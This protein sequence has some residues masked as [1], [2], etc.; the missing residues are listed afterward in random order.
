[1]FLSTAAA[2][3]DVNEPARAARQITEAF[4][5]ESF[6]PRMAHELND[7]FL[8]P[9]DKKKLYELAKKAGEQLQRVAEKQ[10]RLKQQIED[11]NGDDWDIRYGSTGLWRKLSADLY[12]TN[13]SKCE[14]DYYLALCSPPPQ[15]AKTAQDIL[16]RM[17]RLNQIRNTAYLQF[18]KAKTLAL[19]GRTELEYKPLA[20][21]EFNTLMVR[22]DMDHSISFRAAI[23]KIKLTGP[24]G[25]DQLDTLVKTLAQNY[26]DRYLELLL[27]AAF[28]QRRYTPQAFEKTVKL[29]PQIE[30]I[31]GSLILSALT[32]RQDQ[33]QQLSVFEAELAVQAIRRQDSAG[34]YK[35]LLDELCGTEKF[36]TP[37]ILYTA[38]GMTAESAPVKAA[39]LLVKA[40]TLQAS[41]K[42]SRLEI[43]AGRIAAQAAQMAYDLFVEDV[44]NCSLVLKAFDNYSTIAD[45]QFD[46]KLEYLYT[47]VLNNC[48]RGEQGKELL[49]KIAARA[50]GDWRNRAKRDLTVQ[51]IRQGR[52]ENQPALAEA[53]CCLL[54]VS[55]HNLCENIDE[56]MVLLSGIVDRIDSFREDDPKFMTDCKKL[57]QVC[58]D[59]LDSREKQTAGLFLA[60]VSIF[61]AAKNQKKL[62]GIEKLLDNLAKSSE[63]DDDT[64]LLR[65]RARLFAAQ[66]SFN[67][68]AN[69]WAQLCRMQENDTD[70]AN[71]P[72]RQWWRAKFYELDCWAK[73]PQTKKEDILHTIEV[74]NALPDIPPLWADKLKLLKQQCSGH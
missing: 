53:V 65:C 43:S 9:D 70:P 40:S 39:G 64:D 28:L 51:T 10:N 35:W 73:C 17:D 55:D 46:E 21:K 34:D 68:A 12:T 71:Q 33:V 16:A 44:N 42:N 45:N 1:L 8:S 72:S 22:S 50:S 74:L 7:E 57:A 20:E 25:P 32:C 15:T 41:E 56:A 26:D 38:A 19:L 3:E 29:F 37:L 13:L 52:F 2:G 6:R 14:I 49:G 60:E 63:Q 54:Q 5:Q 59:C 62:S 24:D 11:Y 47:I 36:Q 69:F 27:S 31:A 4:L 67:K 23:E 66:G 18:L 30:D 58:Y 48:G 61:E